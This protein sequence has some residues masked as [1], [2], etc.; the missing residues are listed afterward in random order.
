ML[1]LG[2]V[3]RWSAS[4]PWMAASVV[5]GPRLP[6]VHAHLVVASDPRDTAPVIAELE[7][8]LRE[9]RAEWDKM[10]DGSCSGRIAHAHFLAGYWTRVD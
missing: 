5:V 3:L 4:S 9:A 7:E 1:R 10:M 2:V 8:M 6:R